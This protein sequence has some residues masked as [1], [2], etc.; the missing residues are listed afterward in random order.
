M[1]VLPD[2]RIVVR[3]PGA[4]RIAEFSPDGEFLENWNREKSGG[5]NTIVEYWDGQLDDIQ[6]YDGVLSADQ[7][8][9]RVIT[10][11]GLPS[12]PAS[13]DPVQ[14]LALGFVVGL[15]LGLAAVPPADA[16]ATR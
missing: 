7:V 13:P 8:E 5:F 4:T 16:L 6:V 12:T 2:G 9:F 10:P 14:N 3:D 11:P 15:A 1:A